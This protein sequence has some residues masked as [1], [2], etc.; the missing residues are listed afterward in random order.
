MID[1]VTVSLVKGRL[2]L[3]SQARV[4]YVHSNKNKNITLLSAAA[5][6][7]W[8]VV[9]RDITTTVV[10]AKLANKSFPMRTIKND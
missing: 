3:E 8:P 6:M 5:V 7:I 4:Y 10:E 1:G 9:S 2:A